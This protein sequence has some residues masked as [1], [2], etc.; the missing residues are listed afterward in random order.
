MKETRTRYFARRTAAVA[1]A[2]VAA[3]TIVGA[4]RGSGSPAFDDRMTAG[5]E[6]GHNLYAKH[7]SSCHGDSGKGDGPSGLAMSQ[8]PAD[9]RSDAIRKMSDDDLFSRIS[10]GKEMMPGFAK[11]LSDDERRALVRYVRQLEAGSR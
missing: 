6:V 4:L 5:N 7:C 3:L 9:L 11:K 8:K 10:E 2:G 1:L